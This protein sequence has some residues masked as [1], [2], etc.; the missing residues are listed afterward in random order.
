VAEYAGSAPSYSAEHLGTTP[1]QLE[2]TDGLVAAM[3]GLAVHPL[4]FAGPEARSTVNSAG[5]AMTLQEAYSSRTPN[6]WVSHPSGIGYRRSVPASSGSGGGSGSGSGSGGSPAIPGNAP[7]TDSGTTDGSNDQE[8]ARLVNFDTGGNENPTGTQTASTSR[9]EQQAGVAM[10]AGMGGGVGYGRWA[11]NSESSSSNGGPTQSGGSDGDDDDDDDDDNNGD[12]GDNDD[13]GDDEEDSNVP[14]PN[15]LPRIVTLAEEREQQPEYGDSRF[16]F[17]AKPNDPDAGPK[18]AGPPPA[19]PSPGS[20]TPPPQTGQD[21]VPAAQTGL[22]APP[23]PVFNPFALLGPGDLFIVSAKYPDEAVSQ[24]SPSYQNFIKQAPSQKY[25][26][27]SARPNSIP[28]LV[29]AINSAVKANGGPFNRILLLS[30]AGGGSSGPAAR[31]SSPNPAATRPGTSGA[32]GMASPRPPSVPPLPRMNY[33]AAA[34]A[35]SEKTANFPPSL[36]NAIGNG[37]APGGIFVLQ[38]C[39]YYNANAENENYQKSWEN[40]LK[41]IAQAAGRG[42][43]ASPGPVVPRCPFRKS[44]THPVVV[45]PCQVTIGTGGELTK[46]TS[47]LAWGAIPYANEAKDPGKYIGFGPD[48]SRLP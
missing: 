25:F 15:D 3:G 29:T 36:A 39:G 34:Q 42:F 13:D 14:D 22:L 20:Q 31:L 27:S 9:A 8:L 38:S 41:A 7:I 40:N 21:A 46:R 35:Q 17:P 33:N 30:H 47:S 37:L 10:A 12:E 26:L 43:Y 1:G 18:N 6:N 44:L 5:N 48:G 28:S 24:Y 32:R 16:P 4:L 11:G 23:D 19:N 2:T 45:S